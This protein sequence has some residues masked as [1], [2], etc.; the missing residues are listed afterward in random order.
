MGIM[1]ETSGPQSARSELRRLL[2][3]RFRWTDG[4]ADFAGFLA[5]PTALRLLGPGLAEPYGRSSVELVA[6]PEAR[7]FVL[8]G[9]VAAELGVG[10]VLVRK[11]GA[12]HPGP[13]AIVESEPDWRGRRVSFELTS[14]V[15]SGRRVLLVD[16]WIETGS[17]ASAVERAIVT[18]GGELVGASV[19]VDQAP[20]ELKT[21][22][23]VQALVRASELP[24]P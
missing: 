23:R 21:A 22:L 8:G 14:S 5:D 4:H 11:A 2:V 24:S 1:S 17:Q 9:L 16:D 13:K 3:E 19:L 12:V 20:D 18:C 10:L 7:G 6:A 15:V